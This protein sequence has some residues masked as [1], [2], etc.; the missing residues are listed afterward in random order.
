MR[1]FES[2][3]QSTPALGAGT[4]LATCASLALIAMMSVTVVSV[5]M[6]YVVGTPILGVNEITEV[7]SVTLVML[8]MPYATQSEAHVRVDVLDPWLGRTGRMVG[9]LLAR[10]IGAYVLWILLQRGWRRMWDAFEFE[11]TTNMLELPLGPFYA[12]M[13]AGFALYLVVLVLQMLDI[14]RQGQGDD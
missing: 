7:I 3:A 6:R 11:D 4:F 5:F 2:L 8:A 13:L 9:D 12:L 1:R 14:L 10:G